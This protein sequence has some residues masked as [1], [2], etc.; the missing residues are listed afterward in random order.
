MGT[1][2]KNEKSFS[3]P[4]VGQVRQT[5]LLS[6]SFGGGEM[7]VKMSLNFYQGTT[8]NTSRKPGFI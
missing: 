7:R 8:Y 5:D 3:D 2:I 6:F 4:S 1:P